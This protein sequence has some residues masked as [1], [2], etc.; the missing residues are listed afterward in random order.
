MD[1]S[2]WPKVVSEALRVGQLT[3]N[4]AVP[5]AKLRQLIARTARQYGLQYP[6]P[7]SEDEKFGDFLKRFDSLVV[8]LRRDGQDLLIA[9]ADMPQL[10]NA[11]ENERTQL[12]E[13]LFEAFTSIPRGSPP[14]L[15]WYRRA[16][17]VIEWFPTGETLDVTQFAKIPPATLDQELDDRKAFT[18]L[19]EID[20]PVRES[21]LA[22]LGSHSA[23]GAFSKV[24]RAH[25]LSRKWHLYR[26]QAVTKRIKGWCEVEQIPWRDEWIHAS[27]QWKHSSPVNASKPARAQRNIFGNFLEDLSEE[28]RRRISIPLDIVLKLLHN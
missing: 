26:F 13:D 10:L 15:P 28:D 11:S 4:G 22:S 18:Q 2:V 25:G 3:S 20:V 24:L 23:L 5:G 19:N 17:D 8:V 1:D 9:P 7:G 14:L 27:E 6:V 12:R 16:S 21:L